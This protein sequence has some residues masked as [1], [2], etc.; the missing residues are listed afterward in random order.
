LRDYLRRTGR[1]PTVKG[2]LRRRLDGGGLKSA[3][4]SDTD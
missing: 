4:R 1:Q 3:G 2:L